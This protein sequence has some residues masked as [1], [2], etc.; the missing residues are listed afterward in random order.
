MQKTFASLNYYN[1]RLWFIGQILSLIGTWMQSTAQGYLVYSLTNSA[2]YLGYIGFASGIPSIIF[3]LYG[4]L[5]AD[6]L[7]RRKLLIIT[8]SFMMVLAFILAA[9]VAFNR[10]QPWMIIVLAFFLGTANAFDAPA[11]QAFVTELVPREDLT[12]AIALNSIMFNGGAV[13]GPAIAGLTY[14]WFGPVW[15]FAING[16]SFIAVIT[17]LFLMKIQAVPHLPRQGSAI[18]D[19]LVGVKFAATN[20]TIRMLLLA[21]AVFNLFGFSMVTLIPAWAVNILHGDVTTNGWLVSARGVGGLLGGLMIAAVAHLRIRGKIWTIGYFV[22]PLV[23]AAIAVTRWLPLSLVLFGFFGWAL[24]AVVNNTNA[25]VQGMIPDEL[26]GRVMGVYMLVLMGS[27][28]LGSLFIGTTAD[29]FSEPTAV[30]IC[31]AG[32]LIFALLTYFL[33][34]KLR[35]L[36]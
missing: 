32:L 3:T 4:G 17:A 23:L 14:A 7:P 25:L 21:L 12:N 18:Q 5:I 1:Y 6:R 28:P 19:M 16:I 8:Q 24:M 10:I 35:K 26:R 15:C 34:P 36:G 31:A 9:L 29:L 20:G 13:V 30:L 27:S 22:A 2:A 33:Q 11:R